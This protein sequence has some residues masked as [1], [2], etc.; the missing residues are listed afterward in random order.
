M[1]LFQGLANKWGGNANDSRQVLY[2][3]HEV[4]T[5]ICSHLGLRADVV[6]FRCAHK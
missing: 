5:T 4:W 2:L 6:N 3:S 1:L